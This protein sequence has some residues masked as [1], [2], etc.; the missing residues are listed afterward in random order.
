MLIF[1]EMSDF[2]SS[3]FHLI[4]FVIFFLFETFKTQKFRLGSTFFYSKMKFV[5]GYKFFFSGLDWRKI[6]NQ[7]FIKKKNEKFSFLVE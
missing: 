3:N 4:I 1:Q 2:K 7:Y 5:R 6:Q